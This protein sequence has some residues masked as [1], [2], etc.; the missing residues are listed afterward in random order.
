[1]NDLPCIVRMLGVQVK[2]NRALLA[3]FLAAGGGPTAADQAPLLATL[4]KELTQ[5]LPREADHVAVAAQRAAAAAGSGAPSSPAGSPQPAQLPPPPCVPAQL[6]LAALLLAQGFPLPALQLA[7]PAVAGAHA[8]GAGTAV[9][10]FAVPAEAQIA[11]GR[12]DVRRCLWL[13]FS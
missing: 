1:M 11:L 6:N 3:Y 13:L 2:H 9:R 12:A 4:A 8:L 10:A 5:L 7:A